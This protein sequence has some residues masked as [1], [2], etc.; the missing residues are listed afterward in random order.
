MFGLRPKLPVVEVERNWIDGGFARLTNMLGADRM[1]GCTVVEPTDRF[2]PDP[3]DGSRKALEDLFRRV[4]GYMNVDPDQVDLEIIPDSSELQELLP[5][6]SFRSNH[7]AGLHFGKNK[8]QKALIAVRQSLLKDPLTVVATIAHE[9]GHVILL[10]GGHIS[11]DIEDMEPMTDLATVYLGLGIFT[12]NACCRF[13][14]FRDERREGW[15]FSRHGYLPEEAYGYALALFAKQRG[16]TAPSWAAHLTTNV[17]TYF[18]WSAAWLY[19]RTRQ[20]V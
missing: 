14:K 8:D 1:L 17:R 7:P 20:A 2:F 9:L 4:C 3:W 13:T 16:E 19:D 6:Y 18:R 15:S 5:E 10:G 11:R 12:A